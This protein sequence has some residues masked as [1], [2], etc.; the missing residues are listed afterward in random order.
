VHELVS[1][2]ELIL[3]KNAQFPMTI[4][5]QQRWCTPAMTIGQK[6]IVAIYLWAPQPR[7][8]ALLKTLGRLRCVQTPVEANPSAAIL[9][10][11]NHRYVL[12][13]GSNFLPF[14]GHGDESP[15]GTPC[16]RRAA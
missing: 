9:L 10:E 15:S 12:H 5:A 14:T 11:E 8:Q 7:W 13:T 4:A 16:L 2:S 1:V 6:S 3:F